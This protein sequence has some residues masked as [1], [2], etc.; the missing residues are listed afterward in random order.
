MMYMKCT[1]VRTQIYLTE[2]ERTALAAL[3]K[4][5]HKKQSQLI[6]EAVDTLVYDTSRERRKAVLREAAGLWRGRK[7]LPDFTAVRK[8]WDRN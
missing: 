8:A 6:R 1:M 4:T 7:D 3:A 5:R 2:E